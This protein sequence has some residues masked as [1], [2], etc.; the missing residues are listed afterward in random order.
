ME[1]QVTNAKALASLQRAM[2]LDGVLSS[3]LALVIAGLQGQVKSNMQ[4]QGG[5]FGK[6]APA[7]KWIVAKKGSSKLF[8]GMESHV[9]VRNA[10]GRSEVVFDSP[11]EWT[12][13]QHQQ[14]FT[15]EPT[16]TLVS[17]DVVNP[18]AVGR[19]K[20]PVVFWSRRPTVVPPRR[21]WPTAEIAKSK[22][23]PLVEQWCRALEASLAA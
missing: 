18:A 23:E 14:G 16:N 22:A 4:E 8:A 7:S 1:I 5:E 12:L 20:S 9:R 10:P 21:M 11:G 17:I 2:N 3:L 19:S 6:W 15:K 13:T